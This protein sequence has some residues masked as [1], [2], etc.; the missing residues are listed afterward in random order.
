MP[1]WVKARAGTYFEPTRFREAEGR[2]HATGGIDLH[3]PHAWLL[4]KGVGQWGWPPWLLR[5]V[6]LP[7]TLK[8]SVDSA[9]DYFSVGLGLALW[10]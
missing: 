10:R 4:R 1:G 6:T 9:R 3:L 8:F 2:W 7:L 5:A